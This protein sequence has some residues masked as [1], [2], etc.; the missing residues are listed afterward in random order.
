[1]LQLSSMIQMPSRDQIQYVQQK[2]VV[3]FQQADDIYQV[4]ISWKPQQKQSLC[5]AS[6]TEQ[7]FGDGF[8]R[9][10]TDQ[11]VTQRDSEKRWSYAI[12]NIFKQVEVIL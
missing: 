6:A 1:M 9:M 7:T 11:H 5:S 2:Q 10:L 4:W 8:I 12:H 3:W